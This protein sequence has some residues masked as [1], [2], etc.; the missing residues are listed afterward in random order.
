[1]EDYEVVSI[2]GLIGVLVLIL[3]R[4]INNNSQFKTFL[5]NFSYWLV[6]ILILFSVMY[7]LE[8]FN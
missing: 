2:V 1:M 3:P 5:Q 4:F 6:I 8:L 7:Y